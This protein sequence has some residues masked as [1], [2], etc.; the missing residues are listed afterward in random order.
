[1]DTGL[2]KIL[3]KQACLFIILFASHISH[4]LAICTTES[5]F[6]KIKNVEKNPGKS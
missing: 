4:G 6:L 3:K 1:M 2:Y 5:L